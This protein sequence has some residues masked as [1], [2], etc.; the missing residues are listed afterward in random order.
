[1]KCV[2]AA[3]SNT[4]SRF[5]GR[6]VPDV[7]PLRF[8]R[9]VTL[10]VWHCYWASVAQGV[11]P[12]LQR[13]GRIVRSSSQVCSIV[14]AV[15]SSPHGH[16]ACHGRA[17]RLAVA[18]RASRVAR[19][20]RRPPPPRP[21]RLSPRPGHGSPSQGK[22]YSFGSIR[23]R[24]TGWQPGLV[25]DDPGW[26]LVRRSAQGQGPRPRN[27]TGPGP[28]PRVAQPHVW[29]AARAQA[30]TSGA[31]ST[32]PFTIQPLRIGRAAPARVAPH[33]SRL[34]WEVGR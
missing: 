23:F 2:N 14:S 5:G 11:H 3:C 34:S 26:W 1:M 28:S 13:G 33:A 29:A 27:S 17:A 24:D 12:F 21:A 19:L 16:G 31:Y 20:A 18:P 30:S 32:L 9:T 15:R 8:L 10:A 4:P 22:K 7:G 6:S 25:D